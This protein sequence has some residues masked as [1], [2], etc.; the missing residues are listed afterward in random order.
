MWDLGR[1]KEKRVRRAGTDFCAKER[2][3]HVIGKERDFLGSATALHGKLGRSP[4]R[5]SVNDKE[6]VSD[7]NRSM[8]ISPIQQIHIQFSISRS[9]FI[10]VL[11]SCNRNGI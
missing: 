5:T 1:E 6:P 3:L 10:V 9:E 4:F 8:C 7:Y 2:L 11:S